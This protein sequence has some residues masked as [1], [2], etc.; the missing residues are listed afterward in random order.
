MDVSPGAAVLADGKPAT[1]VTKSGQ[2]VRVEFADG[3]KVWR[4]VKDLKP[5]G[6][7]SVP[8]PVPAV[9]SGNGGN[10]ESGGG[11]G[12]GEAMPVSRE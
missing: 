4:Q 12:G 7:A 6:G 3:K 8:V 10:G 2:R 9:K 1:V 11:G 5:A